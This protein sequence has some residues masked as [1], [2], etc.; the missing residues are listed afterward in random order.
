[1]STQSTE[2]EQAPT[3]S[4]GC[5]A[6]LLDC[7]TPTDT[8]MLNWLS[9]QAYYPG[10]HPDDGVLVVVSEKYAPAGSFNV[11]QEAKALRDAICKC[12]QEHNAI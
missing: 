12:M 3:R 1:M 2:N 11:G 10:E 5:E 9:E 7:R 4:V 8:E 6:A